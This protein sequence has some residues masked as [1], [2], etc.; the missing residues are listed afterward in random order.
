MG[1]SE[2]WR[3]IKY[4]ETFEAE[5]RGLE[6]RRAADPLCT[7]EDIEGT[8]NNLYI[9]DGADQDGRGC[10]Q[11]TVMSATIAA[12]EHFISSWHAACKLKCN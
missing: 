6:R 11:D 8:L 5:L 9:L 12:Y 4:A 2:N 1:S 10:V 7:I 3:E